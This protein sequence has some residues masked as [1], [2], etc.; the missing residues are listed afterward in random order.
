[1]ALISPDPQFRADVEAARAE[2]AKLRKSGATPDP[3]RCEREAAL[4]ALPI[5]GKERSA[6]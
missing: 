2:L 5:L 1:M 4:V 3:A 6:H